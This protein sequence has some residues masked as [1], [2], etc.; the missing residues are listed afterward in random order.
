MAYLSRIPIAPLREGARRL[1]RSPQAM[2]AAVQG[3]VAW[4]AEPGRTLWRVDADTPHRPYLYAVT[5]VQPDWTHL[6]EQAGWLID[7]PSVKPAI[8]D[9]TPLLAQ[10]Q[11]GQEY[12]FR[13]TAS[14]VQ[15]T[16]TPHKMSPNQKRIAAET[17]AQDGRRRGF[18][19]GHRTAKHQLTWLATRAKQHGF[20]LREVPA[21]APA[22]PSILPLIN[23]PDGDLEPVLDASVTSSDRHVFSK[24]DTKDGKPVIKDG[25]PVRR[26]VTV[27]TATFSGTLRIT[28]PVDLART[29]LAGMGPA[30]AY[31]CGLL[32]LAS[33]SEKA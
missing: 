11:T 16:K 21:Q 7:D 6:T 8:A 23:T 14:P 1:L 17:A 15:N 20:E 31:G 33:L 5:Q 4:H 9:Y 26:Q 27:Q 25:K 22:V 29:L 30:K 24:T 19:L 32:T 28:E 12:A 13:L 2:H 3:A 10:L 18:R